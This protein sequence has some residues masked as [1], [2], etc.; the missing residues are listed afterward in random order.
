MGVE[1]PEK[2]WKGEG[3]QETKTLRR[4]NWRALNLSSSFT[5][6]QS[7]SELR[8]RRSELLLLLLLLDTSQGE[9]GRFH[10]GLGT[11]VRGLTIRKPVSFLGGS[12]LARGVARAFV[13]LGK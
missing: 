13:K 2:R 10:R 3:D 11:P 1:V 6:A 9:A 8:D 4:E 12:G 7:E 5:V